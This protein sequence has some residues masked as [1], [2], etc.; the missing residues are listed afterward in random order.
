MMK[1]IMN[2]GPI[3]C[4]ISATTLFKNYGGGVFD[5]KN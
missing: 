2:N 5:S 4:G 3:V 1:E